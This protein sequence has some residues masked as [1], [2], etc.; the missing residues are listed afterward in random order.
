M[1]SSEAPP[2]RD[3]T[4]ISEGEVSEETTKQVGGR[5]TS[6]ISVPDLKDELSRKDKLFST[7]ENSR[8]EPGT[9]EGSASTAGTR[10]KGA[11]T[12]REEECPITEG[13][14]DHLADVLTPECDDELD[15]DELIETEPFDRTSGHQ[16]SGEEGK[17]ER[18]GRREEES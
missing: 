11:V 4:G 16:V 14:G 7:G 1:S 6:P 10:M 13:R 15:Y 18:V 3:S 12:V 5:S 2:P 9:A 17:R 8:I